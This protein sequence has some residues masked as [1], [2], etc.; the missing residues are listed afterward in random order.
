ML[1]TK[2]DSN[3]VTRNNLIMPEVYLVHSCLKNGF[4]YTITSNFYIHIFYTTYPIDSV[5]YASDL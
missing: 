3:N 2:N 1:Y 5:L 4:R